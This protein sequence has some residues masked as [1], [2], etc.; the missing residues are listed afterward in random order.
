MAPRPDKDGTAYWP[1]ADAHLGD[2]AR[3]PRWLAGL[4]M[5]GATSLLW[6]AIIGVSLV[7]V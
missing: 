2:G 5:V 7:A 6:I 1:D 3:W 4:F